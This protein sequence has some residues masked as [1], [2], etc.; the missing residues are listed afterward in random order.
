MNTVLRAKKILTVLKRTYPDACCQLQ[1]RKP[2]QLLIATILSAQ[3]TDKRVNI[4]TKTLFR[5]YPSVAAFARASVTELGRDIKSVGFFRMKAKNIIGCCQMLLDAFKG[6]LPRT[7]EEMTLLPGVGRKTANVVLGNALGIPSG[8]AV[9]TH[10]LR[11]SNRLG[12]THHNDPEKI[13]QD[14]MKLFPKKEWIMLPHYL[15]AHGRALC[16]ARRPQCLR[17]PIAGMCPSCS[18]TKS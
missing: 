12:F 8:I 6:S 18:R 16:K 15:I 11:L 5:K 3:C 9:D 7:I 14:L 10:V 4:V 17:C 13:E 1:Y 2:W